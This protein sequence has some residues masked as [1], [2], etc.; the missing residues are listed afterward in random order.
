MQFSNQSIGLKKGAKV[1]TYTFSK[2]EF[3]ETKVPAY[4]YDLK[5]DGDSVSFKCKFD[6]LGDPVFKKK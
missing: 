5:E 1:K 2:E 4:A 3:D 6:S